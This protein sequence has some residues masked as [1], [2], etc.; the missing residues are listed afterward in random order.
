MSSKEI[1]TPHIY[2]KSFETL[3]SCK[4]AILNRKDVQEVLLNIGFEFYDENG[5]TDVDNPS[6]VRLHKELVRSILWTI[7]IYSNT[8]IVKS[9]IGTFTYNFDYSDLFSFEL[10]F[11]R[12]MIKINSSDPLKLSKNFGSLVKAENRNELNFKV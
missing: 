4:N 9:A 11:N 1:V 8:C 10:A 6:F 7:D 3:F 5:K 12:M 2:L